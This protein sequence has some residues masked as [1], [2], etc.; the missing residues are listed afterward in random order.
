MK[1]A[2]LRDSLREQFDT[3]RLS[4]CTFA[5]HDHKLE[6]LHHPVRIL[7]VFKFDAN[8]ALSVSFLG[9]NFELEFR[10]F[11]GE[12]LYLQKYSTHRTLFQMAIFHLN[13]YMIFLQLKAIL[14]G[15][16]TST[17][18]MSWALEMN[19]KEIHRQLF[20]EKIPSRWFHIVRVQ[21]HLSRQEGNESRESGWETLVDFGRR[22]RQSMIAH[23]TY[24][25]LYDSLL[26]AINIDSISLEEL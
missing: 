10:W 22:T 25:V 1:F 12:I 14:M 26:R 3:D 15:S 21:I 8:F 24:A 6:S 23:V 4:S 7:S 19:F 18:K 13:F 9:I 20:G 5:K 17:E 2:E 16:E 11:L